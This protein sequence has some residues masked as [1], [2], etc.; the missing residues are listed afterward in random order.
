MIEDYLAVMEELAG[1]IGGRSG[2]MDMGTPSHARFKRRPQPCP[3]I[4]VGEAVAF[5]MPHM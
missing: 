1:H 3:A 4:P 5:L 2:E